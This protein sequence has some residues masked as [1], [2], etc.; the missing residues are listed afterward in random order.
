M[1][2]SPF[3]PSKK[4]LMSKPLKN[5]K[6]YLLKEWS[7]IKTTSDLVWL[8]NY[9]VLYD[10]FSLKESDNFV[11]ILPQPLLFAAISIGNKNVH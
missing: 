8:G 11:R 2:E 5:M 4:N 10:M 6:I 3:M 9:M 7:H 1:F